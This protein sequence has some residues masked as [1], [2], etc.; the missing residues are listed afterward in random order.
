MA[1]SQGAEEKPQKL[2]KCV[3]GVVLT[4]EAL[5]RQC[6]P[7]A[8]SHTYATVIYVPDRKQPNFIQ[9]PNPNPYIGCTN[10]DAKTCTFQVGISGLK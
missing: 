7:N 9:L 3:D 5:L 6:G 1:G 2:T 4:R 10:P 8:L